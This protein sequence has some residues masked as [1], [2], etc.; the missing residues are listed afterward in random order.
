MA[1]SNAEKQKRYRKK[2]RATGRHKPRSG[3]G[4]TKWKDGYFIAIDGEGE[5]YGE[6][7]RFESPAE[8]GKK[9]KIYTARKH[10][11]TMV[12][13]S[14]GENLYNGGE[15]LETM[16]C[17]D[18]LLDLSRTH[19]RGIF[20]I[21]AGGYDI[22]H[23]LFNGFKRHELFAISQTK[24]ATSKDPG[25][26][27]RVGAFRFERGNVK[28]ELEYRPRKSLTLRRGLTLKQNAEGKW[29]KKW[30]DKMTL[31][32]VF[33]FFQDNF[34]TVVDKWLGKDYK[35]YALIKRM[36]ALRGDFEK[37]SKTDIE[38]YNRAELDALVR[39]MDKVRNAMDGLEF[40]VTRWDGAGAIAAAMM[41]KHK[42]KDFMC[43][44][45][46]HIE[47]AVR[48]A[49]A[50]GRI[51]ICKIGTFKQEVFDYD[52]NSAYPYTMASLPCLAHGR[53]IHG[54]DAFPPP[55]F[56]LVRCRFD[57]MRDMAFYPLFYRTQ[58]MQISFPQTGE[59]I[60]WYPEYS[61]A[62]KCAGIL[63]V[64]EWWHFEAAC[65]HA[66]FHWITDYYKTR[67]AWV[68]NPSEEWQAGAEK[69]L[70]L[71]LNSL[72]GKSAQQAGGNHEGRRPAYHQL[73]WA[74][75]ITSA[76]RARLFSAAMLDPD[77][78]IG[79][80]TDG[81]FATRA[82]PIDSSDKKEFGEWDLKTFDGLTL[83]MAGIYWWHKDDTFKHFS[84]GFDKESMES[85][86]IID[87]AW[88]AGKSAVDIKMHRLI[89]I[90]SAV[91]SDMFWDMRG[92]FTDS[93]RSLNIS[94]HSHKRCGCN[95]KKE[96]PHTKPVD[97]KPQFNITYD[98]KMQDCSFP[99]PI[100]WA[101]DAEFAKE[102]EE[103]HE[104][105]DTHNI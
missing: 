42:I 84:R 4:Y 9:S 61:A 51:E 100:I 91:N 104:M 46:A 25:D 50:G 63:E 49:Y 73:E 39:I 82:L 65:N 99:Y 57:F 90:G 67:Q 54:S 85:P 31:W 26:E 14:T 72:Y 41:R 81:I 98:K 21:F 16:A 53:W 95:V 17:L 44:T 24:I 40:M 6:A 76:T 56:T 10:R 92:R 28:Y 47:T 102:L 62:L 38:T 2:L 15:A 20:V 35:H 8:P 70:K 34:I 103:E 94:G 18:W 27:P 93:E 19:R 37:V 96:R 11:Y 45:P 36:K 80:A 23:M 74:G 30:A 88:K 7:E 60:Y 48:T 97:L 52:I 68:K 83:A 55:G 22:N 43:E 101:R 1:I 12:A 59:G 78:I 75:Y 13:A 105:N 66:P 77:A 5:S 64:I 89:G 69:I 86:A 58:K 33:G 3:P 87:K 71:G 32:D 29:V 79:F